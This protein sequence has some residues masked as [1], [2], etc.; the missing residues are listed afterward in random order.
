MRTIRCRLPCALSRHLLVRR[1]LSTISSHNNN[2]SAISQGPPPSAEPG[3]PLSTLPTEKLGLYEPSSE[4][5]SCGVGLVV[6]LKSEPS[7]DVV[8]DANQVGPW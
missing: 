2:E 1:P 3:R 4:R 5:D 8:D 6:H 7:R